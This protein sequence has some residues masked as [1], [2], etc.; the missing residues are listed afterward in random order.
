M[1]GEQFLV[2]QTSKNVPASAH[3]PHKKQN[4]KKNRKKTPKKNEKSKLI[5]QKQK[6]FSSVGNHKKKRREPAA[7]I[8]DTIRAGSPFALEARKNNSPES[9]SINT[10]ITALDFGN[11][12]TKQQQKVK[13]EIE[14]KGREGTKWYL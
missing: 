9:V 12:R 10:P 7:G 2:S 14:E 8:T 3:P 6:T 13:I 11:S 4:R 5:K 1:R